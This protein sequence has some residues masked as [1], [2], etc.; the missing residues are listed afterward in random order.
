MNTFDTP[1]P[2][3]AVVSLTAAD[4]RINAAQRTDTTIEVRPDDPADATDVAAAERIRVSYAGGRLTV[5][6]RSSIR[7]LPGRVAV[8]IELPSGSAL[9]VS[10]GEGL[11]NGQ[12][13]LGAVRAH[14]S[15][16]TSTSTTP[17]S[18]A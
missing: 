12:G 10:A 8:T 11:L 18:C 5:K 14:L 13:R 4:I 17:A 1:A 2:I 7:A 16:G 9:E 3:T 6:D 15:Q